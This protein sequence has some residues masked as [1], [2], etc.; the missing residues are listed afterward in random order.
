MVAAKDGRCAGDDNQDSS[1]G[2]PSWWRFSMEH[3]AKESLRL[4]IHTEKRSFD[5]Y[6]C[7]ARLVGDERTR[8]LFELLARE[9]A[10]H[11][12]A[13]LALYPGGEFGDLQMLTNRPPDPNDAAY[14][15]LLSEVTATTREQQA[16]EISLREEQAC[17]EHYAVLTMCLRERS[18]YEIFERALAHTRR[19]YG[20]ITEEYDRIMGMA[21]RPNQGISARE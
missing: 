12:Q 13:F 2:V 20:L 10:E 6:R 5:F 9:E 4:A 1:S 21:D 15:S 8:R 19:H 11:M 16:L 17:I 3:F 7:A 14:R 18:L